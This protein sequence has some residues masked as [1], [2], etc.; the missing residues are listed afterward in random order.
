MLAYGGHPASGRAEAQ[1]MIDD[2]FLSASLLCNA[3]L[4]KN[5]LPP[6]LIVLLEKAVT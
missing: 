6:L 5:S 4:A 2:R 3:M 1:A